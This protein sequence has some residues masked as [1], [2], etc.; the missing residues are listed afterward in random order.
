M[1]EAYDARGRHVAA[2]DRMRLIG[3]KSARRAA[4]PLEDAV[5]KF[6]KQPP[7][8]PESLAPA[9]LDWMASPQSINDETAKR[10]HEFMK[11]TVPE[12]GGDDIADDEQ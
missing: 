3:S 7:F 4:I 1:S 10:V 8:T 12:I 5:E 11:A 2:N 9:K 6:F